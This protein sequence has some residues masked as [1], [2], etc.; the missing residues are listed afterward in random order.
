MSEATAALGGPPCPS[1][2]H[3]FK[4]TRRI[5][6]YRT[7]SAARLDLRKRPLEGERDGLPGLAKVRV[8]G[9]NLVV[10]SIDC[11][12]SGPVGAADSVFG[13]PVGLGNSVAAFSYSLMR[14]SH[15]AVRS[16]VTVVGGLGG[17]SVVGVGGRCWSERWGRC[18][19]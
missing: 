6:E 8:A 11:L 4:P 10:R 17:G 1:I 15:R 18:W 3:Q 5:G 13:C 7:E 19:L 12:V 9:S 2:A 14:P 16:T